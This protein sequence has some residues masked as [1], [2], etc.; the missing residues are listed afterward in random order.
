MRQERHSTKLNSECRLGVK[1]GSNHGR[2]ERGMFAKAVE[3]HLGHLDPTT[4]LEVQEMGRLGK[5]LDKGRPPPPFEVSFETFMGQCRLPPHQSQALNC[6]NVH[7]GFEDDWRCVTWLAMFWKRAK[8]V[9]IL[10]WSG[11]AMSQ[12]PGSSERSPVVGG[13]R[14]DQGVGMSQSS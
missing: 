6:L 12:R 10:Q 14:S 9:M 11:L 13:K 8:T 5:G 7:G 4:T 1:L 3:R 2:W